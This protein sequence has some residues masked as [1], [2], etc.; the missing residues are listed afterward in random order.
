MDQNICENFSNCEMKISFLLLNKD[1]PF[2][3]V[4]A[5]FKITF[6]VKWALK[7]KQAASPECESSMKSNLCVI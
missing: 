7:Q 4:S 5:Q 2:R 6:G 1:I 3:L